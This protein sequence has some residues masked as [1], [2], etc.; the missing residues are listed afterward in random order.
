[1]QQSKLLLYL[2]ILLGLVMGFLYSNQNDPTASVPTLDARLQLSTLAGLKNVKIDD[3][4]LT[5]AAFTSLK[6]FGQLPVQPS[7]SGRDNPFQ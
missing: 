3:S 7:G 2:I 6:V 5:S 4:I 1:M